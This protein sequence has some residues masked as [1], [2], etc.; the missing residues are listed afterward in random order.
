MSST[1]TTPQF[2][3]DDTHIFIMSQANGTEANLPT[4]ETCLC[5]QMKINYEYKKILWEK[6]EK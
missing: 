6:R 3:T 1:C 4:S 5:G 2:C